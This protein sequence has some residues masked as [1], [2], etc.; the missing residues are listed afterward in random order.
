MH[1][2]P[3]PSVDSI[4]F[5]SMFPVRFILACLPIRFALLVVPCPPAS[6]LAHICQPG[7]ARKQGADLHARYPLSTCVRHFLLLSRSPLK[8]D[9]VLLHTFFPSMSVIFTTM[10]LIIS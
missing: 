2:R 4:I 5:M 10:T 1:L 3:D 9:D 7:S 6:S 8:N